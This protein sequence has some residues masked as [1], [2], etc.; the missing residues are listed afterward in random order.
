MQ[1][2][3]ICL[4][5]NDSIIHYIFAFSEDALS[6]PFFLYFQGVPVERID[7]Q[8]R[9][10]IYIPEYQQII[11]K[12]NIKKLTKFKH[13]ILHLSSSII[14]LKNIYTVVILLITFSQW[15]KDTIFYVCMN[16]WYAFFS[17]YSSR[18]SKYS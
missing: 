18:S 2:F 1:I 11:Q 15:L 12:N 6:H 8:N 9:N 4:W 17:Y 10:S 3:F 7:H 14:Q 13:L 5:H 16:K